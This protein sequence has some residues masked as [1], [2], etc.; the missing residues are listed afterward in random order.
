MNNESVKSTIAAIF[1][2]LLL[3]DFGYWITQIPSKASI[4]EYIKQ[5]GYSE[6]VV[7]NFT[8]SFFTDCSTR[9]RYAFNFS[10]VKDN[11]PVKGVVCEGFFKNRIIRTKG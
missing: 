1:L 4:A 3:C 11:K 8:L 10:A 5:E 9:D 7:D 6:A 2:L